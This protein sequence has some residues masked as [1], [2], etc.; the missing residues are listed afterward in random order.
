MKKKLLPALL[1]LAMVLGMLPLAAFAAGEA[2]A[3]PAVSGYGFVWDATTIKDGS[4]VPGATTSGDWMNETMY[5]YFS[6]K[7]DSSTNLWF[8][9]KVGEHTWGCAANGGNNTYAFSF[10]N[11]GSQ[12]EWHPTIKDETFDYSGQNVTHAKSYMTG[13]EVTLAV[14]TPET[15]ITGEQTQAPTN[16]GDAIFEKTFTITKDTDVKQEV[17]D[18]ENPDPSETLSIAGAGYLWE[19]P[20]NNTGLEGQPTIGADWVEETLYMVLDKAPAQGTYLWCQVVIG[21]AKGGIIFG[22]DGTHKTFAFSFLNKGQWEKYPEGE[23]DLTKGGTVELTLFKV[24]SSSVPEN[25]TLTDANKIGSKTVTVAAK[26]GETP[27]PPTPENPDGAIE[28]T[29]SD[30]TLTV[31]D[32]A[33][34]DKVQSDIADTSKDAVKITVVPSSGE[35]TKTEVPLNTD[36]LGALKNVS[37]PVAIDTPQG[38]VSIPANTLVGKTDKTDT[39]TFKMD[40]TSTV[41][42]VETYNVGFYKNGTEVEIKD[43]PDNTIT[44]TFKTSFSKGDKVAVACEGTKV[45]DATVGDSGIVTVKTT[46]LST[47][48]I[49]KAATATYVP[50]DALQGGDAKYFY[51]K[52]TISG[53]T[54]GHF[55]LIA[56]DKGDASFR[57]SLVVQ[58][59]GSEIVL[60]CQGTLSL[61]VFDVTKNGDFDLNDLSNVLIEKVD[62]KGVHMGIPVAELVH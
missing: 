54:N 2:T 30:N 59:E 10:L 15:A 4:L 46:H 3:Q 49:S 61:T 37:K 17:K 50:Y 20:E 60:P 32:S 1:A 33:V 31:T 44:L 8:Q 51:G 38:G 21:D 43:L 6:E 48:T 11:R 16:L 56:L 7:F 14:Y 58:A 12:W 41:T 35:A 47:W 22:G 5:V 40:N 45:T 39:V 13:G 57:S 27:T 52:L 29:V 36:A 23:I 55:Y 24:E 42:N 26:G 53:L 34:K 62:D 19:V 28:G 18:E 9:I 25:S